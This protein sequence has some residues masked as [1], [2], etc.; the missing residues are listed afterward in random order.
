[1]NRTR[2]RNFASLSA[3]GL[4]VCLAW[5]SAAWLASSQALWLAPSALWHRVASVVISA[6]LAI[7]LFLAVTFEPPET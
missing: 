5:A 7:H 4:L 3:I 6:S 1:M 2:S